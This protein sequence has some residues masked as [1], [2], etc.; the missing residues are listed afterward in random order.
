MKLLCFAAA[1]SV[2]GIQVVT[3]ASFGFLM[4][5]LAMLIQK[6]VYSSVYSS[7]F[8]NIGSR[9]NLPSI[10]APLHNDFTNVVTCKVH[11]RKKKTAESPAKSLTEVG[12]KNSHCCPLTHQANGLIAEGY[13]LSQV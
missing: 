12:V 10:T 9:Q 3:D 2:Q 11:F 4:T 6:E 8:N 1:V 13:Q 5:Q 7:Y